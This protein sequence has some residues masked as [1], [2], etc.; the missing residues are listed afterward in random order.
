M[1]T[2]IK[3]DI[4]TLSFRGVRSVSQRVNPYQYDIYFNGPIGSKYFGSVFHLLVEFPENYPFSP[5]ILTFL[6][7]IQIPEVDQNTGRL[8]MR[9]LDPR[10]WNSTCGLQDILT[11]LYY[12]LKTQY[13]SDSE[14]M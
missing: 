13:P 7:E 6:Q 11:C 4:E 5:P 14:D 2:R 10:I 3:H 1:T 8:R 12:V 9:I